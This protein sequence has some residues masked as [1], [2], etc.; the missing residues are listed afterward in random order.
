MFWKKG[1]STC[2]G[3]RKTTLPMASIEAGSTIY[4]SIKRFDTNSLGRGYTHLL[5]DLPIADLFLLTEKPA[6]RYISHAF[7]VFL[8]GAAFFPFPLFDT[9][10]ESVEPGRRIKN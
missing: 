9:S 4:I 2:A 6:H 7:E 1:D 10:T 8:P 5:E 3:E